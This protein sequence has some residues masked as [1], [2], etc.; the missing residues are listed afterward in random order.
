MSRGFQCLLIIAGTIVFTSFSSLVAFGQTEADNRASEKDLEERV[1]NL[2]LLRANRKSTGRHSDPQAILAQV[3]AD[4]NRLQVVNNELVDRIGRSSSLDLDLVIKS[5]AE[6][7]TL[8]QKLMTNLSQTKTERAKRSSLDTLA[9]REQLKSSLMELDKMIGE[10]TTNPV[11]KA[12]S[13]DDEKLG[14][15]AL[16]DLDR[17]IR[18]SSQAHASAE[19]FIKKLQP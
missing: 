15:K 1:F 9:D 7:N 18:L 17:I 5:A 12:A 10:F 14:S 3:Q 8:A 13:P 19:K 16:R 11:F 6:I 4:F 2:S